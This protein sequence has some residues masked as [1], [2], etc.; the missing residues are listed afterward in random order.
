MNSSIF[1]MS[2]GACLLAAS[3][4]ASAAI[5][6]KE[7]WYLGAGIGY[8][9][10]KAT[11]IGEVFKDGNQ[12]NS[13]TGMKLYGGYQFDNIWAVEFEYV[14]FGKYTN[15]IPQAELSVRSS[16]IGISGIGTI[17]LSSEFSVFGKLGAFTKFSK[18]QL[19]STDGVER[20]QDKNTSTVP[21]VGL[22]TEY[23]FTQNVSLRA[24][25]EY[26]GK[27]KEMK[28]TNDLLSISVRYN[29]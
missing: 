8:S 12:K 17:P 27:D 25:Y 18:A 4:Y 3:T 28:M 26:F 11:K 19:Q 9:H 16:G 6:E 22:G 10:Y 13:G 23:H 2:I 20:N 24:E 15:K 7:G 1:T 5:P 14:D 21:M 29:F